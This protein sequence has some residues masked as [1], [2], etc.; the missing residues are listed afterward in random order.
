MQVRIRTLRHVVV[1]DDINSFDVHSSPEEISS[2]KN[3]L[4]EA[5]KGLVLGKPG[6]TNSNNHNINPHQDYVYIPIIAHH[7]M[8]IRRNAN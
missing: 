6:S 1:E 2:N 3:T 5:L 7:Q 8:Y 4:A